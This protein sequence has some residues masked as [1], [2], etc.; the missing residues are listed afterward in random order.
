MGSWVRCKCDSLVHKNLFCGTGI[1]LIV[2]ENTLDEDVSNISAND[3]VSSLIQ[4]SVML[5]KC[6]NC[7]RLIILDEKKGK[8]EIQ[9]YLP[10]K[11]NAAP[12]EGT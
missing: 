11:Q 12:S 8:Y 10:E 9:F 7:G 5:L 2:T 4:S 1:S 6:S 3:F